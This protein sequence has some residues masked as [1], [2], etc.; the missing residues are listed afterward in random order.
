MIATGGGCARWLDC[1][2]A[3]DDADEGEAFGDQFLLNH[4]Y[5]DPASCEADLLPTSRIPLITPA[6]CIHQPLESEDEPSAGYPKLLPVI[7]IQPV[8]DLLSTS[9][10]FDRSRLR[11][12]RAYA[13]WKWGWGVW[14]WGNG[15]GGVRRLG[16]AGSV[17][18]ERTTVRTT[19][20]TNIEFKQSSNA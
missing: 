5:S 11:G 10:A 1:A 9:R 15:G 18:S 8:A 19:D 6:S 17:W 4:Q 13:T 12:V 20:N 7:L 16:S 3:L 14:C 2:D